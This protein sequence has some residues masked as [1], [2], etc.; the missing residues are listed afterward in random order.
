M[1][2]GRIVLAVLLLSSS[3]ALAQQSWTVPGIVKSP[4]QNGTNYV[5][6]LVLANPGSEEASVT[7]EFAPALDSLEDAYTVG[8]GQ[9]LTIRDVV[10]TVFGV[11]QAAGALTVRSDEPLVIRAR[12]YNNAPSGTFGVALP[13]VP[14]ERLLSAGEAADSLWVDQDATSDRG[15]RTNV[16]VAFPDP[17]GG[18]ATVTLYDG[19]GNAAGTKDFTL[20]SAGFQQFPV[21]S[22]A[23]GPLPVGRAHIDVTDGRAAGYAVVVDNVTGDG[24]LY[25]FED[26]PAGAQ[27]VVV[28]GVS[29]AGGQLGTFWR[30]DARF[31]NPSDAAVTVTVS[32]NAAGNSNPAP[33]TT[34]F[35]VPAGQI[36][37]VPDVLSALLGLPVGSSGALRF[38]SPT[39]VAVLCRTSNLD[40]TGQRPGTYGAQ[41]KAVPLLSYLMSA[42]AGAIVTGV[43]QGE[44]FRTNVG[45]AAGPDGASYSLQLKNPGGAVIAST[46][47]SLGTFGWA[48]PNVGGLFPGTAVPDGSQVLV[49]VT[50]GSLDIYDSSIDNSSGDPVV[51][52]APPVPAAIP[53][54]ATIGPQGG[55]VQSDDGRLT[56]RIPAGALSGPASVAV[57]TS[58][59]TVMNGAGAAYDITT[60]APAFAKSPLVTVG[61]SPDDL[62]GSSTDYLDLAV[63]SAGSLYALDG[64]SCDASRR[65]L[66]AAFAG[67]PGAL[68][69][70]PPRASRR[71][72]GPNPSKTFTVSKALEALVSPANP[73]VLSGGAVTFSAS[74]LTKDRRTGKLFEFLP[75]PENDKSIWILSGPGGLTQNGLTAAT[76]S[77][78]ASVTCEKASLAFQYRSGSSVWWGNATVQLLSRTWQLQATATVKCN[79]CPPEYEWNNPKFT[80]E[81]AT[82]TIPLTLQEVK[83]P[84]T[85]QNDLTFVPASG[86]SSG[87]GSL[88]DS[89]FCEQHDAD[90]SC[91]AGWSV[92]PDPGVGFRLVIAGWDKVKGRFSFDFWGFDLHEFEALQWHWTCAYK[93]GSTQSGDKGVPLPSIAMAPSN[94]NPHPLELDGPSPGDATPCQF[95]KVFTWSEFSTWGGAPVNPLWK[96]TTY[97]VFLYPR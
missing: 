92:L 21:A 4:G 91:T 94:K 3:A 47:A 6:D 8:A 72:L 88:K 50:S 14:E 74:I 81:T 55:S 18:S 31:Y 58:A 84:Q 89:S 62:A 35:T 32:F 93:D 46:T 15:Y 40:P 86:S 75:D 97:Y 37:D 73:A 43:S 24:S 49:K 25:S 76:Y 85:L 1:S 28:N 19:L 23:T 22:F 33:P 71:A 12:T 9:S 44:T 53:S 90:A 66:T 96:G 41:Q 26:L 59:A 5:S 30:T 36:A 20:T 61:Y 95:R 45:F 63:Q 69:T 34:T 17:A 79:L 11:G 68:A 77:A 57:Q 2:H 7:L 87:G 56:F 39:P 13:V 60:D 42:D 51:T 52:P 65:T 70:V 78:P 80:L 16:A 54:S 27:D 48:Q 82:V 67:F 10:A 38:R 29:R 83:N 64:A